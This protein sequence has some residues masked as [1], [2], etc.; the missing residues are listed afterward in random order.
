MNTSCFNRISSLTA[1][2]TWVYLPLVAHLPNPFV[3]SLGGVALF[4]WQA[5]VFFDDSSDPL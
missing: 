5:F 1:S 3:D 4:L 2:F